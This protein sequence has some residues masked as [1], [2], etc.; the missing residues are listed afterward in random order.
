MLRRHSPGDEDLFQQLL[1]TPT[2]K[3]NLL[4][5]SAVRVVSKHADDKQYVWESTADGTFTVAEDPRGPT[6]VRG[7]EITLFLKDDA[8]EY[9]EAETLRRLIK[10]YSEFITFPIHLKTTKTET[11]EVPVQSEDEDATPTPKPS[12]DSE[13]EE[14]AVEAE[15][16]DSKPAAAKT[17]TETREVVTWEL[18]NDQKAIWQRKSKDISEEEYGSFYKAITKATDNPITWTHFT[19]EGEVRAAALSCCLFSSVLS[20][21]RKKPAFFSCVKV[22]GFA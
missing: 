15:D 2:I 16:E 22:L 6:L 21:R 19:A 13:E 9:A 8:S 5:S 1:L 3:F 18:V 17:K 11:V 20:S 7:S 12:I 4:P 14:E 10:R